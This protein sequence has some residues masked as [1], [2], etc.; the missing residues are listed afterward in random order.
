MWVEYIEPP[1]VTG[2]N[3]IRYAAR[4]GRAVRYPS[5]EWKAFQARVIPL[6]ASTAP[7]PPIEHHQLILTVPVDRR[8]DLDNMA[9][10][11]HNCLTKAGVIAD[12]S[13]C[14]ELT[15]RRCLSVGNGIEVTVIERPGDPATCG[16]CKARRPHVPRRG[17][18]PKGKA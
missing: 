11:I 1:I 3:T 17:R 4:A 5:A 15:V 14:D 12:D 18:Q 13:Y 7:D 8:R 16:A 6:F 2:N 10:P 9:T